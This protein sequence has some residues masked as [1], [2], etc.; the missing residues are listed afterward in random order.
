M[1]IINKYLGDS[2][3]YFITSELLLRG[4]VA[5]PTF[6]NKKKMDITVRYAMDDVEKFKIIEVK[7]TLKTRN[8][9]LIKGI[10]INNAYIIIFVNYFEKAIS[11]KP[12]I[13]ILNHIEWYELMKKL[14]VNEVEKCKSSTRERKTIRF[15]WIQE[16]QNCK[17][18]KIEDNEKI[19]YFVKDFGT[20]KSLHIASIRRT[21]G[22][23]RWKNPEFSG[24]DVPTD[25][26][27]VYKDSWDKIKD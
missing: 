21:E 11:E 16:H 8:F 10:P 18:E 13:Y 23:I 9:G 24:I 25:A 27:R 14:I 26:I 4:F 5:Q 2:A 6:G 17:I 19:E 12:D 15:K 3:E 1:E 20:K 7:S 22:Y